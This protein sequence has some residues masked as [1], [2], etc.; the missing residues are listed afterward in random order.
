MLFHYTAQGLQTQC[1]SV[2]CTVCD[3]QG[4]CVRHNFQDP[5]NGNPATRCRCRDGDVATV[6]TCFGFVSFNGA[7]GEAQIKCDSNPDPNCDCPGLGF[8]Q[9]T[10]KKHTTQEPAAPTEMCYC[11]GGSDITDN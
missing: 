10:C 5:T 8:P 2:F 4:D 1:S 9:P 11:D 3:V 7:T 6:E